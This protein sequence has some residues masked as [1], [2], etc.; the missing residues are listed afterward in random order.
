MAAIEYNW[1][2]YVATG[3]I[4][5]FRASPGVSVPVILNT[6]LF[7]K[8][9]TRALIQKNMSF[10]EPIPVTMELL[11]NTR[12]TPSPVNRD[13]WSISIPGVTYT[14]YL[15]KVDNTFVLTHSGDVNVKIRYFHEV[16]YYLNFVT[17][18][19]GKD[20]WFDSSKVFL[21]LLRANDI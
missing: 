6:K 2:R 4:L 16:Q 3:S 9:F 1:L 13:D 20:L 19:K 15:T 14:V 8:F 18:S 5:M 10:F 11:S 7:G 17:G 21:N 12:F